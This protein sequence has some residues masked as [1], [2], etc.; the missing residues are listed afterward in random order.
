M[1]LISSGLSQEEL[2]ESRVPGT[3]QRSTGRAVSDP[4]AGFL[5]SLLFLDAFPSS[6]LVPSLC[7]GAAGAV[8]VSLQVLDT[9][10]SVFSSVE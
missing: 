5:L 9:L 6:C 4:T 10:A 2:L 3:P 7:D 1:T 8:H